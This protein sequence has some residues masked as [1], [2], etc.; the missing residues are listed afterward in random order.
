MR[1]H[2]LP[3]ALY[4]H[5]FARNEIALAEGAASRSKGVAVMRVVVDAQRRAVFEDDAPRAFNLNGEQ[6]EWIL[7]PADF[8]FLAIERAGLNSATV[9]VRHQLV[10]LV[11]AADP[12][13]LVWKCFR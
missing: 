9:V 5:F 6:I 7:E 13:A 8:K 12:C 3:N 10:L 4:R 1:S 2:P 11:T